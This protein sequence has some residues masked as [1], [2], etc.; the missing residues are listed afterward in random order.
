MLDDGAE[1]VNKGYGKLVVALNAAVAAEVGLGK[2]EPA[3]VGVVHV[4]VVQ[5]ERVLVNGTVSKDA[6]EPV[7]HV[8][9]LHVNPIEVA[10]GEALGDGASIEIVQAA[11]AREHELIHVAVGH[12]RRETKVVV[13]SLVELADVGLHLLV[14]D[15]E[16]IPD[17]VEKG[18]ETPELEEVASGGGAFREAIACVVSFPDGGVILVD[19]EANEKHV[20]AVGV[21]I[22]MLHEKRA[23]VCLV[24]G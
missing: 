22:A 10:L 13:V 6:T 4:E 3:E 8:V 21:V 20:D 11:K 18:R 19:G 15:F 5:Q 23:R 12:V 9:R 17:V 14:S 7:L 1:G 16:G 2:D 24:L